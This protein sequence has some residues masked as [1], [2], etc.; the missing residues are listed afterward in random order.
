M[1]VSVAPAG[2]TPPA[3]PVIR[4][5]SSTAAPARSTPTVQTASAVV[6]GRSLSPERALQLARNATGKLA[7]EVRVEMGRDRRL[8]VHV[9][10]GPA[11]EKEV[12]TRLLQVSEI[13]SSNLRLQIHV[14]P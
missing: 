1:P 4:I 8:T 13:V 7:R 5:S 2:S 10:A 3:A 11:A 14:A 6:Q 12:I 9:Y